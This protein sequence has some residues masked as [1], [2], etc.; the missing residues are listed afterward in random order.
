M[1]QIVT[2]GLLPRIQDLLDAIA[3]SSYGFTRDWF[4]N[5]LQSGRYTG[6]FLDGK[7]LG[8]TEIHARPLQ[9]VLFI[10]WLAGEGSDGWMERWLEYLKEYAT[11]NQCDAIEF[12]GRIGFERKFKDVLT[13]FPFKAKRVAMRMEM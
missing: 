13:R 7:A 5:A 10:A 3:D 11:I 8:M 12:T 4:L 2:P 1:I 9:R 6:W